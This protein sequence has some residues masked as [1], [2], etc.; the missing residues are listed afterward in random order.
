M[1]ARDRRGPRFLQAAGAPYGGEA[2]SAQ[3]LC[4]AVRFNRAETIAGLHGN[5]FHRTDLEPTRDWLIQIGLKVPAFVGLRSFEA[6]LAE[7]LREG[8]G[9]IDV[10]VAVFAGRHDQIWDPGW[11]E[12]TAKAIP[13]ATLTYVENSGHVAFIEDRV[14]WNEALVNF[15]EG[16]PA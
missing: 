14:A 6:L 9:A 10:P 15:I 16:N 1:T 5:N 3:A 12:H 4:D 13:G 8:C 7:D 2:E 11:S